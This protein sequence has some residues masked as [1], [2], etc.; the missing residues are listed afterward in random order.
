MT[1]ADTVWA[2]TQAGRYIQVETQAGMRAETQGTITRVRQTK[3]LNR[4]GL[5][6]HRRT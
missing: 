5:T 6:R 3:N 1:R 4:Q 2:E